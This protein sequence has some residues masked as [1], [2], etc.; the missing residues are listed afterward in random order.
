LPNGAAVD[1][2]IMCKF[3]E[4]LIHDIE[5]NER[6]VVR[7]LQ[8][9]HG[10]VIDDRGQIKHQWLETC[11][12]NVFGEWFYQGLKTGIIREVQA[13]LEKQHKKRLQQGCGM[14]TKRAELM[15]VAAANVTELKYIVTDDI[16]FWEPKAKKRGNRE[17]HDEIK[18][19]RKGTVCKYLRSLNIRVGTAAM[20]LAEL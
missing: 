8:S 15:Y 10:F 9:S 14:P 2:N 4:S 13:T 19:Q 11:G 12:T 6:A 17:K 5:T 20:A 1:A 3:T 7:K 18:Q 16:D